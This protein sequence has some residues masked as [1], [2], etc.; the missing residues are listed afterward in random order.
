VSPF[1]GVSFPTHDYQ[2]VGEAVPGRHRAELQL[3]AASSLAL[4]PLLPRASINTRYSYGAARSLNGFPA[5]HSNIDLEG[6]YEVTAR[7]AL[8][9][10][11]GWQV[12]HRGPRPPEL[13]ADWTNHDRF[14]VSSYRNVG[15]GTSISLTRSTEM[16]AVWVVTVSGHDGAHRARTLAVGMTWRFGGGLGGLGAGTGTGTGTGASSGK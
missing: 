3:G 10:L 1:V 7:V 9:A 4:A 15:G 5:T 14:I 12:R 6:G 16:S 13:Q 8:R 11:L 2:T